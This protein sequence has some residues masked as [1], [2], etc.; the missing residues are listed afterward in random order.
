MWELISNFSILFVLFLFIFL[1]LCFINY[2]LSFDL[3]FLHINALKY[4]LYHYLP[5]QPL[6]LVSCVEKLQSRM[7]QRFSVLV[8]ELVFYK[9]HRTQIIGK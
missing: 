2:L 3:G 6:H 9:V 4:T 1:C 7:Q 8:F 5:A